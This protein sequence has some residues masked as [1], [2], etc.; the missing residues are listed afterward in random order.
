MFQRAGWVV[1]CLTTERNSFLYRRVYLEMWHTLTPSTWTDR[2]P[3]L[4]LFTWNRSTTRSEL[5][6][7]IK[8]VC[9]SFECLIQSI[10]MLKIFFNT[11]WIKHYWNVV[12][13][14]N[15]RLNDFKIQIELNWIF[16]VL[17]QNL[18]V[19]TQFARC[20]TFSRYLMKPNGELDS[21][22][23]SMRAIF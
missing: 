12:S 18:T 21:A 7:Y 23:C 2:S 8:A 15:N 13:V 3:S 20:S 19:S 6:S 4:L 17:L 14:L 22:H 9:M 1:N 10:E 16:I 11:S 5:R